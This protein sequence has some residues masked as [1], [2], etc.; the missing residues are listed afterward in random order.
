[1]D[2]EVA[3]AVEHD[4]ITKTHEENVQPVLEKEIHKDIYH[5][6]VQPLT[7]KEVKPTEHEHKQAPTQH[8]E[9]EHDN[10]EA[11]NQK[12][13]AEKAKYQDSVKEGATIETKTQEPTVTGEHVHHHLHE[14]IQ[15]V[16]EKGSSNECGGGLT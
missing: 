9:V 4:T 12:I 10:A 5:T 15:P 1:V 16:I 7:D 13:E 2:A 14:T 3:P 8:R 11:T 6:T